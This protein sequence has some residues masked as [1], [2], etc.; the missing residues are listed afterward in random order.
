[1][2]DGGGCWSW[3]GLGS[4]VSLSPIV[5]FAAVLVVVVAYSGAW[6]KY[7]VT[8]PNLERK[9]CKRALLQPVEIESAW[10]SRFDDS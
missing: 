5:G 7:A 1:M 2:R 10:S 4:L 8:P 9:E 6:S 3:V